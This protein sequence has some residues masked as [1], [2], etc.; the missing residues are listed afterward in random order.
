L[1]TSDNHVYKDAGMK[2][3]KL[4]LATVGAS[5]FLGA[6]VS[7]A[8]ARNLSTSGQSFR[9]AFREVRL[10]AFEE[11]SCQVTLEGSMHARTMA[12]VISSLVGY[13]IGARLGPCTGGTVTIN[14][15][16]LPWHDRYSS[17]E[18]ALP[19]IKS[20]IHHII[21]LSWVETTPFGERC[22]ILTTEA[23]PYHMTF[24]RN[25]TTHQLTEV[26]LSG[27][28]RP[29]GAGCFATSIII[30]TDSVAINP[31]ISVSLI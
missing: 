5:V 28:I 18:G 20:I 16:T 19:N 6:L 2:I 9:A 27:T 21:G 3:A 26:G 1:V 10:T 11:V 17:F 23:E 8:S 13:I 12:K 4:L 7:G 25:T 30:R 14:R 29:T 15:E 22:H 31:G 24:H